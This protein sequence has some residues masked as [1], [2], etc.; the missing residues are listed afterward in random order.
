MS[1]ESDFP[2]GTVV[3]DKPANG[4]DARDSG[5]VPGLGR[6]PGAGSD[7]SLQYFS[8]G[9]PM[10]SGAWRATVHGVTKSQTRLSTLSHQE[11][12]LGP[13]FSFLLS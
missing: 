12:S 6:R 5:S 9:N 10:D 1:S 4:G 3:K 13:T 2:G 8:L 11:T 7:N